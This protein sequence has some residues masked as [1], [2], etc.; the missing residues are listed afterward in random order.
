MKLHFVWVN[1][2][3]HKIF[4]KEFVGNAAHLYILDYFDPILNV[5][6]CGSTTEV[7]GVN[8]ITF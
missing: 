6:I 1:S 7:D 4:T 8:I 2:L 5:T 3:K